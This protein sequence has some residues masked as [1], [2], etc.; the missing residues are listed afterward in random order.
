MSQGDIA[1]R[2][3]HSVGAAT[4]SQAWRVSV[5][6]ATHLVL[7][8]LIPAEDWG[9]YVWAEVVFLVLGAA[10]DLGLNAHTLRV[11][12]RPFGNLLF[13]ELVW[14][15]ALALLG[16]VA[17]PAIALG[18]SEAHPLVVPVLRGM[19]LFLFFE[20][21]AVVPLI[22]FEGE[23]AVGKVVVSELIR[24]LA[25]AVTAITLALAGYGVWSLVVGQVAASA[26]FAASLWS[27]AAGRIPLVRL[28]GQTLRLLASSYRLALIWLLTL[29]VRYIDRLV[30]GALTEP[31]T[32]GIYEF[33]YWTAFIVPTVA[34]QPVGRVAFPA[35][36]AVAGSRRKLFETYRISTVTLL[37]L[38]VPTAYFL[39]L[40]AS[41]VLTLI[42]GAG[43]AGAEVF[44]RILCFA[45]LIDPLGRL[46]GEVLA[47]RHRDW[48]WILATLTTLVSFSVGGIT[49]V[50]LFGARG[51]AWANYLPL[52]GLVMF[53]ALRRLSRQGVL[54]LL[55]D[56]AWVYLLPVPV[57]ALA[58]LA[59][60]L[61]APGSADTR[62][63]LSL[64]AM[65]LSAGLFTLR[66]GRQFRDFFGWRRPSRPEAPAA[67]GRETGEEG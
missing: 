49:L 30:L 64:L 60:H 43:W 51:M 15:G 63:V 3:L 52:G 40:N 21:L 38:E 14:G 29:L 11:T 61:V 1:R 17:A 24:N 39:F 62:L 59:A 25:Y 45:P 36:V 37:C 58:T 67:A 41:R 65:V 31:R 35:F 8:R 16:V 55:R 54:D 20:G 10:R 2:F 44:L 32:L 5:T 27:R 7:R 9:L 57:F 34:L 4:F 50:H 23:L 42:G 26:V 22:Y 33:A 19:T 47:T 53:W 18:L 13:L 46:G 48:Q 6:F 56:L 12:P 66:F 28:R